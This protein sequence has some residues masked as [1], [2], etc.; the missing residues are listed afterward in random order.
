MYT[1]TRMHTHTPMP[2]HTP[3]TQI[4]PYLHS[5]KPCTYTQTYGC[6]HSH[7]PGSNGH[8]DAHRYLFATPS[9]TSNPP[10]MPE[11]TRVHFS[12]LLSTH[13]YTFPFSCKNSRGHKQRFVFNWKF[14]PG[15]FSPLGPVGGW[16]RQWREGWGDG[17]GPCGRRQASRLDLPSRT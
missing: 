1:H 4:H 5:T 17:Q 16:G 11:H 2:A 6:T 10:Y 3:N 7:T 13:V 12:F 8:T 15:C 9:R 14:K